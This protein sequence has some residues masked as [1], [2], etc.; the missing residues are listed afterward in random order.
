MDARVVHT[1][2]QMQNRMH[3][4]L[5][6]P[7]LAAEV[8]LSASRFAHLFRA[9]AGMAPMRYLRELRMSKALALLERTCSSVRDVMAQVG[10]NDPS[11]FARDFRRQHGISPRERRIA[12]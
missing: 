2:E 11:H 3:E 10:Y 1:I 8:G 7:A 9:E 12:R 6:V 5:T 4:A